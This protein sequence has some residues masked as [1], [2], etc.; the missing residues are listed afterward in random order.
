MSLCIHFNF[1]LGK[2]FLYNLSNENV[3]IMLHLKKASF[4]EVTLTLLIATMVVFYVEQI[5]DNGNETSAYTS[6]FANVLSQIK[7]I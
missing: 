3:S 6:K 1:L 4:T 2:E 7:H 5:T